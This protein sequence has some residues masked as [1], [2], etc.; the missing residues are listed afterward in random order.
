MP[1]FQGMPQVSLQTRFV[2]FIEWLRPDPEKAGLIRKQSIEVKARIQARAEADGLVVCSTPPAGSFAKGTDLRRRMVG[3]AESERQYVDCPFVVAYRG[4]NGDPLTL[5]LASFERYARMCYPDGRIE[6]TR[7]SV[8]LGLPSSKINYELVPTLAVEGSEQVQILLRPGGDH[9]RTSLQKHVEFIRER[10]RRSQGYRG[11]VLFNEAVRLV[12]WWC[13]IRLTSSPIVREVPS[14]LVELLCAKAF[15]ESSIW[16]GYA[17]TLMSWFARIQSYTDERTNIVFDEYGMPQ[18][19]RIA[20]RWRV[21]DPV[22][23]EN[24]AVPP[25]WTDLHI[26]ELRDWAGSARHKLRQAIAFELRGRSADAVAVV[27]EIFGDAFRIH[28][29]K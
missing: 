21:I 5:L 19:D 14:F 26:E 25:R 15:D 3:K 22:N 24:N 20:A 10:T 7:S 12:K 11:V 28:S 29:E 2:N 18:P 1:S 9:R 27:S 17:E 8:R 13:E 23:T 6:R 4:K 16:G